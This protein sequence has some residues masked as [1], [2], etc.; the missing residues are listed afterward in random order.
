LPDVPALPASASPM[1]ADMLVNKVCQNTFSDLF[2]T[3]TLELLL[4]VPL[5][6]SPI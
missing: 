6:P 5:L 4:A 2:S 1:M 3:V